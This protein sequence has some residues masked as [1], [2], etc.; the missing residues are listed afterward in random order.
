MDKITETP[1]TVSAQPR[2]V[3][4]APLPPIPPSGSNPPVYSPE[5]RH[6]S[7]PTPVVKTITRDEG[8]SMDPQ[9]AFTYFSAHATPVELFRQLYAAPYSAPE[10]HGNTPG[11]QPWTLRYYVQ[12][13]FRA[14]KSKN[15]PPSGTPEEQL[16]DGQIRELMAVFSREHFK[17]RIFIE[18]PNGE[19]VFP[20]ETEGP[21]PLEDTI[22]PGMKRI[23][24]MMLSFISS[25]LI[26]APKNY[27]VSRKIFWRLNKSFPVANA[28]EEIF[29]VVEGT[30]FE[31]S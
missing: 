6:P 16:S 1:S 17:I 7:N 24:S 9:F 12:D 13:A 22:L 10:H 31:F 25:G 2:E 29:R 20:T 19:E 14:F 26:P 21:Y 4:T 3:E 27:K 18:G 23:A 11:G 30:N 8:L 15:P 28:R 5:A